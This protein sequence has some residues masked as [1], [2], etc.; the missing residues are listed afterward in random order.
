MRPDDLPNCPHCNANLVGDEIPEN[1]RHNF[2]G[3]THGSRIIAVYDQ[4]R[5][6]TA[7]FK[8]PDCDGIIERDGS[9]AEPGFRRVDV[10]VTR[11]GEAVKKDDD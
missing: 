3:A 11:G 8:C 7:Y 4:A 9:F 5:D 6:R 1:R 10:I 2:G